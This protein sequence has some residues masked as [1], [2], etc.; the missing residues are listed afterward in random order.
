VTSLLHYPTIACHQLRC[1]AAARSPAHSDFDT[2][3]LL[4]QRDVGG[5]EIADMGTTQETRSHRIE[6]TATF[7]RVDSE[8][9][10]IIVLGGHL[11]NRWTNRRYRDAVHRVIEPRSA[12]DHASYANDVKGIIPER[13]SIAFFSFPDAPTTVEPLS[14]CYSDSNP[15]KYRPII[16][17][18]YLEGKRRVYTIQ[19]SSLGNSKPAFDSRSFSSTSSFGNPQ[20]T[21]RLVRSRFSGVDYV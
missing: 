11:L 21:T 10:A 7:I 19:P 18:E 1:G 16:A 17:G 5:L 4:F 9:G 3:T 15:R 2:L 14:S 8:P 6:K 12:A 20:H 13:Y